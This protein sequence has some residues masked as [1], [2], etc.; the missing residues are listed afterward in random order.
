MTGFR[1]VECPRDAW[2]GLPGFIPTDVKRA[3]LQ[4]LLEAGF[5]HLDLGSFVSPAAVPQMADTEDVLTGLSRPDDA[6]FLGII[7]N[8]RGLE[9]AVASGRVTSVG[10]PFSLSET[11]QL[12]NTRMDTATSWR[13][14]QDLRQA[15][16]DNGIELVVYLSMGFGNPY[17]DDWSPELVARTIM[18]LRELGLTRLALADTVGAATPRTVENVLDGC[19]SVDQLGLHLHARHDSWLDLVAPAWERGVRWFEGALAGVGGCPF[20][21]DELVG[22]LPTEA[23]VPWLAARSGSEDD[24]SSPSSGTPPQSGSERSARDSGGPRLHE[25]PALAADAKELASWAASDAPSP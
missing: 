24:R 22:N 11:F 7:A 4:A 16:D 21:A 5:R 3:H 8:M 13:L 1:W 6:D 25:L 14:L 19:Q 18:F 9:R 10:Y 17:G 15:A 2:Q 12:R 20:A 23:V